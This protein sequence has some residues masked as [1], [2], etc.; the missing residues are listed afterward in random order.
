M[1][2]AAPKNSN[3]AGSWAIGYAFLFVPAALAASAHWVFM[4]GF[5]EL[6]FKE[7]GRTP[8]PQLTD[9]S[10]RFAP[11]I[12]GIAILL[13]CF[14]LLAGRLKFLRSPTTMGGAGSELALILSFYGIGTTLPSVTLL[15]RLT[16]P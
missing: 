3:E 14:S 11:V 12:Y 5:A 2:N 4:P 9:F 10:I 8:L 7:F 13:L 15:V 16:T 1:D 6:I